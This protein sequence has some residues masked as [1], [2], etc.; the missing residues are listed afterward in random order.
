MAHVEDI[1]PHATRKSS[2]IS[3]P[4]IWSKDYVVP[5]KS[6]P[7]SITDHVHY[8]TLSNIYQA[9]VQSFSALLEPQT[10][11]DASKDA[12]WIS[13]MQDE[14][15]ALEYNNTWNIVDLP[16]GSKAI[17]L[18]WVYKIKYKSDGVVDRF[19]V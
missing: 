17:G 3:K 15:K 12:R 13:V 5:T 8:D 2:R 10:F 1:V 4:P 16:S 7:Y 11:K 9:Y 6:S 14:I 18:K 19:K